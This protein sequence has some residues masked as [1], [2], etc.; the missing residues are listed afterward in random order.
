MYIVYY[1]MVQ[2]L[3]AGLPPCPKG[4]QSCERTGSLILVL[5][6]K[7]SE[8]ANAFD[9]NKQLQE[10]LALA[11]K[12]KSLMAQQN[13]LLA[14]KLKR[15]EADRDEWKHT[16]LTD[17]RTRLKSHL[18]FTI[19]LQTEFAKMIRN[20]T[21]LS[22]ILFDLDGFKTI[23]DQYGH[24]TGDKVLEEVGKVVKARVLRATDV[25]ARYGGDEVAI[26]LPETPVEAACE[27]ATELMADL[28]ALDSESKIGISRKITGSFGVFTIT[29]GMVDEGLVLDQDCLIRNTDKM[30]YVA[31]KDGGDCVY[32][33]ITHSGDIE[34]PDGGSKSIRV[35][36]KP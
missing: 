30:L 1:I 20:D 26:L 3:I 28:R 9:E 34:V 32:C 14:E 6:S 13:D 15:A 18:L 19:T 16:A 21:P 24:H 11:D 4:N 12:E 23:N 35:S 33:P 29:K 10:S 5:Q 8:A 22:L 2:K 36:E 25:A 7:H 27:M 17:L 31:K